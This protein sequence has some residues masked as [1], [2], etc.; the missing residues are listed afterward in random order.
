MAKTTAVYSLYAIEIVSSPLFLSSHSFMFLI[1]QLNFGF[2]VNILGW[3]HKATLYQCLDGP[4]I[5]A[6]L[7]FFFFPP[8]LFTFLVYFILSHRSCFSF[9][10][11]ICLKESRCHVFLGG[12]EAEP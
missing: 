8:S 10:F 9:L 4:T 1:Y 11:H 3:I 5:L 7:L 12:V 6:L 2:W